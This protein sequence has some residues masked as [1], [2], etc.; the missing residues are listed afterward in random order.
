MTNTHKTPH[1]AR[2]VAVTL[3]LAPLALG[4]LTLAEP[5]RAA[6]GTM[7]DLSGKGLVSAYQAL[8]YDTGVQLRDGRGAGRHVFWPGSW[9]VCDQQ[10]GPGSPM[11]H[12]KIVLTVVKANE[13]C[14]DHG[15]QP[16]GHR[17]RP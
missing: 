2:R 15:A 5:A 4:A 1:T 13:R 3:A 7:P 12:Q 9:K 11:R 6:D 10:P 17:R 14:G 16:A 8:N